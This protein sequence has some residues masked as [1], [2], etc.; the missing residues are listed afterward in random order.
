[1]SRARSINP[2]TGETIAEHALLEGVAI[3]AALEHAWQGW[4]V[5]REIPLGIRAERLRTLGDV[6]RARETVLADAIVREMGKP[7]TQARAEVAKCAALCDWYAEHGPA[8]LA[9]ERLPVTDDGAALVAW[10]PI[11]PVLAVMPWNFPLWQVLRAAVP[12]LLAGNG[13]VLKHADNVLGCAD[14]LA[15]AITDAGV[16]D[17]A[18]V[19]CP[20]AQDA[21]AAIIADRRIA[22][23]TVTAG[24]AAGAAVAAAAGQ[25]IKKSVLELGGVDPFVVLADADIDAAA[26][27]AVRSRFL[28]SGQVCIAAK[29]WIVEAPVVTRFTD[30]AVELTAALRV[31]DPA[32]AATFI[33]PLARARGRDD[34]HR[35]VER[36]VADGARLLL[37]GSA[38]AG[39]GNFYAPTILAD[40]TPDMAAGCDELFGPVAAIMTATDAEQAITLANATDYGLSAALWTGDAARADRLARRIE[41]GA[42]FVNGISASD[43]RVPI[44]GIRKSGYGRELSWFG[45]REFCNAKLI[46]AR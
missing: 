22:A 3:D 21:I 14:L 18:F 33:G 38:L 11:G 36:S 25:H 17:G 37:G 4:L 26:E 2:A 27:A 45:V 43:P 5:W 12:I 40:V 10:Q 44:G 24:V 1:M 31:G 32:D 35:G 7:I 23:V 16:A 41:A 9:D 39:P 30:R 29:R 19:H 42:V 20:V 13:F 6:L 8:Y 46:W 34:L 28:N 15:E